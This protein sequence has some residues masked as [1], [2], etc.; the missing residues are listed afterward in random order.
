MKHSLA[1]IA[2]T[3]N[4]AH[5]LI[6]E[7]YLAN[8][9]NKIAN[10]GEIKKNP[11]EAFDEINLEILTSPAIDVVGSVKRKSNKEIIVNTI[12]NNLTS[13]LFI[14]SCIL[15]APPTNK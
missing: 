10:A 2:R 1:N 14:F 12:E 6:A 8:D 15:S 7:K 11:G 13:L 4:K 5:Q 3:E 9:C